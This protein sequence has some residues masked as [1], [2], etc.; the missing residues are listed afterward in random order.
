MGAEEADRSLQGGAGQVGGGEW[1]MG[2]GTWIA[3]YGWLWGW[4]L[5]ILSY[6]MI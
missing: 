1:G 5:P 4:F 6:H 3:G 2:M